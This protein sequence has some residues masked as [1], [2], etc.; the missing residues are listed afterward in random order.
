MAG[1]LKIKDPTT[2]EFVVITAIQGPKG[3]KGEDGTMTFSDLTDE[4]KESLRGAQGIQGEP[5]V[6]VPTGG[7]P[8]QV[9]VKTSSS[10]YDTEWHTEEIAIS[11]DSNG[12]GTMRIDRK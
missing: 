1:I 10:D 11:V 5:G 2:G 12:N 8:G 3:N 6:G 4:Q 7:S 9:L